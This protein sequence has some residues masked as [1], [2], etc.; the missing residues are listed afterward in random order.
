M[1]TVKEYESGSWK[2]EVRKAFTHIP[3]NYIIPFKINSIKIYPIKRGRSVV[4]KTFNINR[5]WKFPKKPLTL[6]V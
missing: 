1:M 2:C 4:L 6:P 3:A 5:F